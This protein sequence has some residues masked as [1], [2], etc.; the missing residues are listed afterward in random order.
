VIIR[1]ED[2]L[3]F[4]TVTLGHGEKEVVLERVL[5]DTGSAATL[6]STDEVEKLGIVPEL[7]D[8]LRLGR[9]TEKS[10]DFPS[11]RER[12]AHPFWRSFCLKGD[13]GTEEVFLVLDFP[14]I[15]ESQAD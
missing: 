4:V 1:L 15:E 9:L 13:L 12:D 14:K 10:G 2:R 11:R 8:S 5:L 3:P 6:F 7:T